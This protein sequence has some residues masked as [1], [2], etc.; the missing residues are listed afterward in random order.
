MGVNGGEWSVS[1]PCRFTLGERAPGTHWI[2]G[3][4]DPRAGL[5]DVEKKK[6]LTLPAFELLPLGRLTVCYV[7]FYAQSVQ[8]APAVHIQRRRIC[9]FIAL[10][11]QNSQ[12]KA[13]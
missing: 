8:K 4:V 1:P 12:Q 5:D 9:T 11:K 10:T 13:K 3:W 7:N 2:G 6:F